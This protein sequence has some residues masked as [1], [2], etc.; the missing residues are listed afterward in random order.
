MTTTHKFPSQVKPGQQDG[1]ARPGHDRRLGAQALEHAGVGC[2]V[3]RVR[4]LA[5]LGVEAE[6]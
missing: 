4:V 2:A 5:E 1:P 6:T 3:G